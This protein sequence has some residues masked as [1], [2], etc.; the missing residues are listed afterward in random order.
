MLNVWPRAALV[1]CVSLFLSFVCTA[2]D[3]S[4]Y[5]SDG[6]LLEAGFLSW[7]FAP[8]GLR[9]GLGERDPPS[10]A[11]L[12][13]LRWECFRIYFESGIVKL[14]S[15]DPQWRHLTAMD[16]YYE[17]GPLPNWIGWYAQQLP[18]GFHAAAAL[19][20]LV[21]EL[22][23]VWMFFLQRRLRLLL[24]FLITPF[25]IA[26]ILTANLGFLNHLV[27][28]L[29]VLLL[30]DRFLCR[31]LPRLSFRNSRLETGNGKLESGNSEMELG[32]LRAE[33]ALECGG[34][35]PPSH[36]ERKGSDRSADL[37][38]PE[39]SRDHVPITAESS[40]GDRHHVGTVLRLFRKKY[41]RVRK[42]R[43]LRYPSL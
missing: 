31:F 1:V 22:G 4:E 11:S 30:D 15:G 29:G 25:Q 19:L 13:L 8:P 6:M 16:H 41:G 12:F 32:H 2:R 33:P 34:L 5:Q 37:R 9:P 3:F 20:T 18:H 36:T 10:R 7:F 14:S 24:F 27:L 42:A 38:L 40:S 17:N 28:V 26:I 21:M 39:S 43:T 23:L 35:T